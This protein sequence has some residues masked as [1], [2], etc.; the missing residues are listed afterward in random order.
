M[1]YGRSS[2]CD[3]GPSATSASA[4]TRTV[5]PK[6][7]SR[8]S[9]ARRTAHGPYTACAWPSMGGGGGGLPSRARLDMSGGWRLTAHNAMW[10]RE[11]PAVGLCRRVAQ[12]RWRDGPRAQTERISSKWGTSSAGQR[13]GRGPR[14]RVGGISL[15]GSASPAPPF[16]SH[17]RSRPTPPRHTITQQSK[18]THSPQPATMLPAVASRVARASSAALFTRLSAATAPGAIAPLVRAYHQNVVDHYENPR[19]VGEHAR[20][21]DAARRASPRAAATATPAFTHPY[22][23]T[24][25]TPARHARRLARQERQGRGHRPGGR[26]RVRRRHEAAGACASPAAGHGAGAPPPNAIP[27]L[28][29]LA[30]SPRP[31]DTADQGRRGRQDH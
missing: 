6:S 13:T 22:S 30:A 8:T 19:N 31:P 18:P 7:S 11:E 17:A 9:I 20:G 10:S 14:S 5:C 1:R 23:P 25:L 16:D 2:D 29:P 12:R 15:S 3:D 26:A 28:T 21:R 24:R 4:I 27:A